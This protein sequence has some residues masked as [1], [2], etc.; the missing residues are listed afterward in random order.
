M[1]ILAVLLVMRV[2]LGGLD[3]LWH[4][5]LEERLPGRRE[6]RVEL[7][8]HSGRELCYAL[9]FAGLAWWEWR[10]AWTAVVVGLLAA[11]VCITLADFIVED[12]TRRLPKLERVLHTVLAMN[13]GALLAVLGP[14]LLAWAR[15]PTAIARVDYGLASWLLTAAAVGVLAW[16]VRYAIGARGHFAAATSLRLGLQP[17]RSAEPKTVLVTGATG[18]IG[19][20]LVY[21]LVGRGDGVIVHARSAVKA[22]DLFGPHVDIVTDLA[23]I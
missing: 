11:E 15:L 12:R 10:G 8:L 21:R 7:A 4:H 20:K 2:A 18:F 23:D 9:M 14:A 17:R 22:A 5:E 1:S 16:W 13:F 19:R 3:N 6:A